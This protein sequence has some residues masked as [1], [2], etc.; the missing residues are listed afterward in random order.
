MPVTR[1][2]AERWGV[3]SGQRKLAGRP[4]EMADGLIAATVIEHDLAI[5]T[6]NDLLGV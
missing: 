3:L 2:I 5:V 6:R 4:L 1:D